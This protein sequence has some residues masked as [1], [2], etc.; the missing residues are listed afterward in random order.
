MGNTLNKSGNSIFGEVNDK[1][2]GLRETCETQSNGA[3]E[4]KHVE[5]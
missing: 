4:V 1:E 3:V 2:P 5:E